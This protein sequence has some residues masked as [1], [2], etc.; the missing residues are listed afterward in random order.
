ML[1]EEEE[2]EKK[3]FYDTKQIAQRTEVIVITAFLYNIS[4]D[5]VKNQ[6]QFDRVQGKTSCLVPCTQWHKQL[7]CHSLIQK[8]G[9]HEGQNRQ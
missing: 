8:N 5:T 2:E 3:N 6:Y 7:Q 9:P 1:V 4:I